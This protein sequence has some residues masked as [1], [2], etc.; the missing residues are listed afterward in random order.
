MGVFMRFWVL[1]AFLALTVAACGG[2]EEEEEF[3]G[4]LAGGTEEKK[5]PTPEEVDD[6]LADESE[7]AYEK[8]VDHY[9][10][11][12]TYGERWASVWLDLARYA[13]SAGYAE[14]RKRTIWAFRDYVIP[15]MRGQAC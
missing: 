10:A 13:D 11:Q 2:G 5:P 7:T 12:P 4:F 15:L 1:T 6:F 8:L 3:K 14:D 9:L